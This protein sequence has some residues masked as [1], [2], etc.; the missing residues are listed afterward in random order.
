MIRI[1]RITKTTTTNNKNND[2]N[3]NNNNDDDDDDEDKINPF[4]MMMV[5]YIND[6]EHKYKGYGHILAIGR[7]NPSPFLN[8]TANPQQQ[9]HRQT[10]RY[11]SINKTK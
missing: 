1:R 10:H 2:N 6:N 8:T 7:D 5:D 4:T 11:Q 9:P 3:K